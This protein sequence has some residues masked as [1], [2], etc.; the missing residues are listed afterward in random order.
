METMGGQGRYL[1]ISAARVGDGLSYTWR[2]VTERH[3]AL[4]YGHRMAAVVE[5]T[6]DATIGVSFEDLLVTSWNRA[7]E[8]IYGYTAE[9]AIGKALLTLTPT[10][11]IEQTK[12]MMTRLAAGEPVVDFDTVR[13][14]KDGTEQQI[15]V[16]SSPVRD[17]NGVIVAISTIHRNI[18]KEKQAREY[19]NRMA[20]VV[21]YSG[22]AIIGGTPEGIIT[23]WNPAA[24]RMYGYTAEEIIG[25]SGYRLTPKHLLRQSHSNADQIMAGQQVQKVE[26]ERLRKDATVFPAALTISPVLDADGALVGISAIHRDLSEQREAVELS[27]SMIRASVDAMVSTSPDGIIIDA[28]QATVRL[29]GIPRDQLIGTSFSGY[30]TEPDKA[31]QG[32]GQA[33]E[34]GAVTDYPL[35]L[36]HQNGKAWLVAVQ[37]NA[38]TYRDLSGQVRGVFVVARDMTQ[39]LQA[40]RTIAEQQDR[41][42]TRLAELE[43]FQRLTVGRELKMIELKKEIAHLKNYDPAGGSDLG[44]GFDS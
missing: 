16:S 13:I 44:E 40:Q 6:H 22:D 10:D 9:E 25:T 41:E 26:T 17:A 19:A 28:N 34:A 8:R 23:S 18:T 27:R 14:R 1:D 43:Q 20:A 42:G 32:L 4:E 37:Y 12:A 30:F 5:Q 35:T 15:S 31:E 3:E 33:L 7:A 11:R 36:C 21:E 38:S 39:Q 24:E 29:T 2:D